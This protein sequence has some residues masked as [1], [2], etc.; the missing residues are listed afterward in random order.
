MNLN[1]QVKQKKNRSK[2]IIIMLKIIIIGALFFS[3]WQC[4]DY[5]KPH[6]FPI[7]QVKIISTYEHLDQEFLQNVIMSYIGNGFFHLNAIG[8]KR[9]L[10]KLPWV[11]ATSVR[12][13]W[14]DTIIVNIVEQHAVLQWGTH[15][16]IN[17]K[18]VVFTPLLNTFPKGLP[19]IFGPE[20][21]EFEIFT[22]YQKA[23]E[24][25]EPLDLS[26][27]QLFFNPEHYWEILLNSNTLIYLK[28]N[29]LLDQLKFLTGIYPKIIA[30]HKNQP[31]SIDLRYNTD[32]F[33][34]RWQ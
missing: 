12:R 10:L 25:F 34:V 17:N 16:L 7:K 13:K 21:R 23:R 31:K 33:A 6:N 22:L 27:K 2:I 24:Y 11:Y 20:E 14:P 29:D 9:Q 8:M 3:L 4:W 18:G 5:T 19:V 28:E 30:G 26:I 32:G 15:A 1:K